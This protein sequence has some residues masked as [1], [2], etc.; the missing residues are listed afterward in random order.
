MTK[1]IDDQRWCC[2]SN[3]RPERETNPALCSV[4][5]VAVAVAD[6]GAAEARLV[7]QLVSAALDKAPT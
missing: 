3:E 4:M 6:Q 2:R 7:H 1:H 5:A